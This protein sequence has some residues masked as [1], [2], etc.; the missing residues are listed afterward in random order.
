MGEVRILFKEIRLKNCIA[1]F[2]SGSI[3]AFGL[4][5]IHAQADVTEGGTL[6]LTLL[7]EHWFEV[8][9]AVSG[10]LLN[11][12]C[13]FIGWKT[14]GKSFIV[15][16][17]AATI[18]F[19]L[20][21]RIF[22]MIGPLFAIESQLLAAILGAV[23]VG[24]GCGFAILAGGA[25][26]GDDALAMSL[27][28]ILKIRIEKVYLATDLVV[29]FL[30]LSYIPI[31]KILYSLLTVVLSGQIIGLIQKLKKTDQN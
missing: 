18:G 8:S 26:S 19:S 30:S 27:S 11:A 16:S 4:F 15:Y 9:P 12:L 14:L 22:E 21:Y 6:G 1:A 23:F 31:G 10:F 5:N 25:P 28:K 17:A 3:L 24:C 2:F 7:L 29:L 13:Y 20:S